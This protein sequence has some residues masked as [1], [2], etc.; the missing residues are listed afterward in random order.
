MAWKKKC[1]SILLNLA[2]I[3]LDPLWKHLINEIKKSPNEWKNRI[4]IHSRWTDINIQ[5]TGH[6]SPQ[7][8]AWQPPSVY[9]ECMMI[10]CHLVCAY[11]HAQN[12]GRGSKGIGFLE[13]GVWLQ[14]RL[15]RVWRT[16]NSKWPGGSENHFC[17]QLY[18]KWWQGQLIPHPGSQWLSVMHTWV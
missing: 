16:W 6:D 7:G 1:C 14:H 8:D 9:T 15:S 2:S 5:A 11:P 10:N 3:L 4:S 13:A 17:W 12:T 18:D